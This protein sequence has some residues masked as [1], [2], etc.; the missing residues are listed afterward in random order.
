MKEQATY[1]Y[2]RPRHHIPKYIPSNRPYHKNQRKHRNGDQKLNKLNLN[3]LQ[4][5]NLQ[6]DQSNWLQ[7]RPQNRIRPSGYQKTLESQHHEMLQPMTSSWP[8]HQT[9]VLHQDHKTKNKVQAL[10]TMPKALQ[11][12]TLDG[13]FTKFYNTINSLKSNGNYTLQMIYSLTSIGTCKPHQQKPL[14]H[15]APRPTYLHNIFSF[16]FFSCI[17]CESFR[18][19][20]MAMH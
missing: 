4:R 13:I 14:D 3:H 17:D 5:H 7:Q 18:A 15:I 19:A 2:L 10:Q 16:L 12:H 8:L 9:Q 6:Q 11:T 1:G 20:L